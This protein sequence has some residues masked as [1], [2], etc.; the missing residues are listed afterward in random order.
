MGLGSRM[1][2]PSIWAVSFLGRT[3]CLMLSFLETVGS[4]DSYSLV[5]PKEDHLAQASSEARK[6]PRLCEAST[7]VNRR[8]EVWEG[9]S[10]SGLW[11]ETR[12]QK[13]QLETNLSCPLL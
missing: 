7:V 4:L 2:K 8:L 6:C 9:G 12:P 11:A 5:R 1:L 10:P 3:Q 13:G